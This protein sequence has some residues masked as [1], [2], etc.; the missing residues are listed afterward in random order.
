MTET[1]TGFFIIIIITHCFLRSA[2]ASPAAGPRLQQSDIQ[3]VK[4]T[5]TQTHK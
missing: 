5:H 3:T 1:Q 2:E 4:N